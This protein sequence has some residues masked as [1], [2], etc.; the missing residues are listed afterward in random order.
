M[1]T[2]VILA[3]VDDLMFS[4]KLS[5]AAKLSNTPLKFSRSID[6]ALADM[7]A[8]TPSMVILDLNNPRID[9]LAIVGAM[10]SDP[11][12]A[13]IHTIGFAQHTQ[14]ETIIA[15]RQAGV[16]EVMARSAFFDR[17]PE[18]LGRA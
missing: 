2:P 5:G 1:I 13:E 10:R 16:N 7:R 4:S 11:T 9:A 15:A 6:K 18:I 17:L 3:I 12:L 14:T 8:N